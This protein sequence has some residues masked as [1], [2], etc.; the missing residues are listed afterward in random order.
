MAEATST[1]APDAEGKPVSMAEYPNTQS[2]MFSAM[3]ETRRVL[4]SFPIEI[5]DSF[6]G[7]MDKSDLVQDVLLKISETDYGLGAMPP[8]ERRAFL[9]KMLASRI[10]DV[11]R[12][13]LSFKRDVRREQRLEKDVSASI[14]TPSAESVLNEN[15]SALAEAMNEL[16]EDYQTVLRL[17]HKDGLSFVQIGQVMNRSPDA[18]RVL[19][20]RA[21]VRLT[22]RVG[23]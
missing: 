12:T 21:L 11:I 3:E 16:P 23:E 5:P 22:N 2:Q 17:R 4:K 14:A 18:V 19:W 13:H 8:R 15:K 6:R 10:V 20:G 7:R 1:G 9:R